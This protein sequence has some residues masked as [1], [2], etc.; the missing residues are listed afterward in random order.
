MAISEGDPHGASALG[1]TPEMIVVY[2]EFGKDARHAADLDTMQRR[3][4]TYG[5]TL[6]AGAA[7]HRRAK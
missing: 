2:G 3:L 7:S 6:A 5:A 4:S 1:V